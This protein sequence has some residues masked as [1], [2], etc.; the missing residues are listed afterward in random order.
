[1]NPKKI[2]LL[3]T[4]FSLLSTNFSEN[5]GKLLENAVAVEMFRRRAEC[6]YYKGRRECDFI[7]K[8]GTKPKAAIQVCWELTPKNETREL[9]G[10]RG[11]H[12]RLRHQR[13]V[14]SSPTMKNGADL[15]ECKDPSRAG[16][17][18][19]CGKQNASGRSPDF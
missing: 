3:D 9:R 15:R 7:I 1:M 16:L 10:L 11:G 2:Y 14:S 5:R 19:A 18:V 12:E 8:E 4:G 17:E 6:F 13:K